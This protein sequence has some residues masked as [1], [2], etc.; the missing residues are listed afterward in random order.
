MKN[1]LLA[2][3]PLFFIGLFIL[4]TKEAEAQTAFGMKVGPNF[5]NM[6]VENE[7][8]LDTKIN[9]GIQGGLYANLPIGNEFYIQP[10]LMY[11]NKGTKIEISDLD[12]DMKMNLNY[13]TL[14]VDFLY[15][16]EMLNGSG[17][18]IIERSEERREGREWRMR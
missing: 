7:A 5:S 17:S 16:P 15:K 9:I 2:V 4:P 3:F 1:I 14:P 18:W 12:V 13:L 11:E 8:D 6:T 10:S